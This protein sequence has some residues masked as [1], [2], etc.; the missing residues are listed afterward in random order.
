M[1][2]PPS[3]PRFRGKGTSTS[4]GGGQNEM[5]NAAD[6]LSS[7]V[8][9]SRSRLELSPVFNSRRNSY[10][11][12]HPAQKQKDG[13]PELRPNISTYLSTYVHDTRRIPAS[14]EAAGLSQDIDHEQ[15][16]I[17]AHT[18]GNDGFHGKYPSIPMDGMAYGCIIPCRSGGV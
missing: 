16:P 2:R 13:K 5:D 10:L 12:F 4:G 18:D 11:V 6:G 9:H 17:V 8:T 7:H 1:W 15:W 14:R 3:S